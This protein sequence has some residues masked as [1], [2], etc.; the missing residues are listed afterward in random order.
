MDAA[1]STL[2]WPTIYVGYADTLLTLTLLFAVGYWAR[3][4]GPLQ[5]HDPYFQQWF[6]RPQEAS[7]S[8]AVTKTRN[9]VQ[10]MEEEEAEIVIFW[11]SQSGTAEGFAY[12]LA[13]ELHNKLKVQSLV[14]DLSDYDSESIALIPSSKPAVFILSTYGE[15]DPTDNA[16]AFWTWI[17][18]ADISLG[19]LN[20]LALG[21]GNSNY[22]YYNQVLNVVAQKLD[23]L[24]ATALLPLMRA[25]DAIINA[26]EETYLD[27]REAVEALLQNRLGKELQRRSYEPALKV[28]PDNSLD[29]IDLHLGQPINRSTTRS[30]AASSDITEVRVVHSHVL[31]SP[32]KPCIHVDLDISHI[33]RFKYRTGDHL[34]VYATN[35]AAEVQRLLAVLNLQA[36]KDEPLLISPISSSQPM[37][38]SIP[39]PTTLNALLTSYLDISGTVS[40]NTVQDLSYFAR[41]AAVKS[42]LSALSTKTAWHNF[43][44]DNHINFGRLLELANRA[45]PH[46]SWHHL[47]TSFVI[48]SLRPMAPRHYSISSSA[49][50]SPKTVSITVGVSN[51]PLRTDPNYLIPGLCSGHLSTLDV[52]A[53]TTLYAKIRR[54]TFKLPV[55]TA[56]PLVLIGAGTGIAPLRAFIH[57]RAA[58]AGIGRDVGPILFFYGCR[59]RDEDY[60]YRSEIEDIA[61]GGL[62]DKLEVVTAFSR[63]GKDHKVYVQD[64]IKEAHWAARV[65]TLLVEQNGAVYLCGS[66]LMAKSAGDAIVTAV[67][68]YGG[69]SISDPAAWRDER[70]RV[71]KWKEDI[72]G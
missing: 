61:S 24:G 52:T 5:K 12:R 58:L 4:N 64:R 65:T 69:Q 51:T 35:A 19:D 40:R 41:S 34:S 39:S 25:D 16:T 10:R 66:T 46:H 50:T 33:P 59:S 67:S 21:L 11:G 48:E 28:V 23:T 8:I 55:A 62:K 47:P 27:W 29:I 13:H 54:S 43:V 14:A 53:S 9:V 36:K 2:G 31:A 15:G 71:G 49:V 44:L 20:Y 37:E 63:E 7:G 6:E 18:K 45:D 1:V 26:T 30:M 38:H 3:V 72:W 68:K 32:S 42:Y 60:L 22:R 57:E 70:R 17:D 56:T